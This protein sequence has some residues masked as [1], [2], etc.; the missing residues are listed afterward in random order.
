MQQDLKSLKSDIV[1]KPLI[2]KN[3]ENKSSTSNSYESSTSIMKLKS[4]IATKSYEASIDLRG[5]RID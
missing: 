2:E 3:S 4:K 5:P 1:K